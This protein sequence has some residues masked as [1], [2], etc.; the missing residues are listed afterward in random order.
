MFNPLNFFRSRKEQKP[1][2]LKVL[3]ESLLKPRPTYGAQL[4]KRKFAPA[5]IFAKVKVGALVR[6][7]PGN[8]HAW[9]ESNVGFIRKP[10]TA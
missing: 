8:R 6:V 1:Q 2:E 9:Y 4:P 3:R 10:Y 5:R 7:C